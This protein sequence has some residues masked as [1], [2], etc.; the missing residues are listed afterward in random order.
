MNT[1]KPDVKKANDF[2]GKEIDLEHENK[3]E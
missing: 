3:M 1:G 2:I